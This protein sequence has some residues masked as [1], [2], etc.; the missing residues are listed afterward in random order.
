MR[1]R[2]LKKLILLN[3]P[4]FVVGLVA[5]NLGEAWRLATGTDMSEKIL[6]LFG[7]LPLALG[8]PWPSLHP[9]DLLVGASCG[10]LLRL[11]VYLHGK[12]AKN[13]ATIRSTGRPDGAPMRILPP[14][15]TRCSRITSF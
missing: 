4:Y 12:N 3:L 1:Q 5:T 2:N 13:I 11:A 14:T 9:L 10:A 8:T 15:S 6:H 7:T